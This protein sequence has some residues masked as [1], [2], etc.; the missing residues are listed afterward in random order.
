MREKI[1][2][3]FLIL[4]STHLFGQLQADAGI[5]MNICFKDLKDN[6]IVLGGNPAAL[7]GV[8]PY[9]YTWAVVWGSMQTSDLLDDSTKANPMISNYSNGTL[10]FKLT[11]KDAAD[12]QATDTVLVRISVLMET[13][14]Y[15]NNEITKGDTIELPRNDFLG[16]IEP[17]KYTWF[18]NY[19]ISDTTA[20]H[21]KAW[22]DTTC[23]YSVFATDS[24]GCTSSVSESTLTVKFLGVINLKE[25]ENL[26]LFVY[27]NPA[28]G[29]N[30]HFEWGI[31]KPQTIEVFNFK[32]TLVGSVNVRGKTS[33]VYPV[34]SLQPGIYLYRVTGP[35]GEK[36]TGKFVVQ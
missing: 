7:G 28:N 18:P 12:N 15:I 23:V 14:I 32:G 19:N 30:I 10:K 1:L 3:I 27:P 8:E 34:D 2:F 4:S 35:G 29:S 11:V 16:G 6:P 9:V 22:P 20:S 24:I 25:E 26:H 5:D 36:Q 17:L 13:L 31:N 33:M 21:P